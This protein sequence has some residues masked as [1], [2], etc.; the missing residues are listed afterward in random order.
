M[1]KT[2]DGL[3]GRNSTSRRKEL[4]DKVTDRRRQAQEG[5]QT[6]EPYWLRDQEDLEGYVDNKNAKKFPYRSRIRLPIP[7]WMSNAWVDNLTPIIND[8]DH[9]IELMGR[10]GVSREQLFTRQAMLD[11]QLYQTGFGWKFEDLQRSAT[12]GGTGIWQVVRHTG[13]IL[14]DQKVPRIEGGEVVGVTWEK[15]ESAYPYYGVGGEEMDKWDLWADTSSGNMEDAMWAIKRKLMTRDEIERRWEVTKKIPDEA[16]DNGLGWDNFNAAQN[17]E[18]YRQKYDQFTRLDHSKAAE[19]KDKATRKYA[20]HVMWDVAEDEIIVT[21]GDMHLLDYVNLEHG[22][23]RLPL[24]MTRFLPWNKYFYGKSLPHLLH[25]VSKAAEIVFNMHMDMVQHAAHPTYIVSTLARAR[26][27]GLRRGEPG[28]IVEVIGNPNLLQQLQKNFPTQVATMEEVGFLLRMAESVSN[29]SNFAIGQGAPGVNRTATGVVTLTQ[30]SQSGFLQHAK[31]CSSICLE[32][33]GNRINDAIDVMFDKQQ[34]LSMVGL[35][36]QDYQRNWTV[37]EMI[38]DVR[39][40][41]KRLRDH[42]E[43]ALEA[44][45]WMQLIQS[46]AA[47]DPRLN[48]LEIYRRLFEALGQSDIDKLVPQP[49]NILLQARQPV[50]PSQTLSEVIAEQ[51]LLQEQGAIPPPNPDMWDFPCLNSF[52]GCGTANS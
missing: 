9:P 30:R 6:F 29:V 14:R 23:K 17:G 36:G 4:V 13:T 39:V 32:P 43:Q 20:V 11:W 31:R 49:S 1:P 15:K 8:E 26:L 7:Q 3:K 18:D 38:A 10:E 28:A 46:G 16:K 42:S 27:D 21:L 19:G 45:M 5:R 51:R 48:A 41:P 37:E 34:V 12:T 44:Q 40:R 22:D 2:L 50:D 35:K 24:V 52:V 47:Q 25:S 33:L